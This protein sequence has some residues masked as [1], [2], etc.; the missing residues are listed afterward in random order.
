MSPCTTQLLES[1]GDSLE[2]E[3]VR[4]GQRGGHQMCIDPVTN[5]LYLFGGWDGENDLSDL[6][7]YNISEEKWTLIFKYTFYHCIRVIMWLHV[8]VADWIFVIE[9]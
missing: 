9:L 3:R 5:T 8:F 6:W 2:C 1:C 4:P 7:S